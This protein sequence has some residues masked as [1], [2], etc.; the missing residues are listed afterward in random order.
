MRSSKAQDGQGQ[1]QGAGHDRVQFEE[2]L[3]AVGLAANR[4]C[5]TDRRGADRRRE[6]GIDATPREL[7]A[8]AQ[9]DIPR[10]ADI[11][12]EQGLGLG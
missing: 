6:T 7:A 8:D 4:A 2:L 12:I 3:R 5:A 10:I 9:P 1:G 11:L